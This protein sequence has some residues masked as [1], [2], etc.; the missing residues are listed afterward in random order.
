MRAAPR[1]PFPAAAGT[2]RPMRVGFHAPFLAALGGGEKKL[3]TLLQEAVRRGHDVTLLSPGPGAPDPATW[4]RLNVDV[5]AGS[6]DWAAADDATVTE[7]SASLDL[8]VALTVDVP[9]LSRAA[10]SVAI[11]QFP[12]RVRTG[13]RRLLSLRAP[14]HLASYDR[15]VVNADWVAEQVARRLGVQAAVLAPPVDG[16]A[17]DAPVA[18][19]PIVLAVGRFFRSGHAKRH[20]VLIDAFAALDPAEPWTLHLVGGVLPADRPYLEAL[21]ARAEGRR[22]VFHPDAPAAELASLQSRSAL[23][24]HAAGFGV[25]ERRHPERLEHFGI[26]VAEAMAHGTVPLAYDAGGPAEIVTDGADGRLWRSLDDLTGATADLMADAAT[27][28]RMAAAARSSARR[29][30]R[31]EFLRRAGVLVFGDDV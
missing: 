8:L 24:W 25:D 4:R 22:I 28:E 14:R 19:E 30:G 2:F 10:S 31:P 17:G 7:R 9:P 26:A 3:L 1:A 5:Q 27:R 11:V 21:R 13:A 6:F 29:F 23:L 16:P 20:D 12:T 15:F 18:R